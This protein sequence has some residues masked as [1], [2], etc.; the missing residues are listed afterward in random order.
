MTEGAGITSVSTTGGG[1]SALFATDK[2]SAA[3]GSFFVASAALCAVALAPAAGALSALD[4]DISTIARIPSEPISPATH[5]AITIFQGR[6]LGGAE[7]TPVHAD[8]V[9]LRE[10]ESVIDWFDSWPGP[11]EESEEL[12]GGALH[13]RAANAIVAVSS[14]MEAIDDRDRGARTGANGS[15]AAL[16]SSAL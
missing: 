3:T 2:P 8:L 6:A 11:V 4:F 7:R 16:S 5:A 9:W 13:D 10:G 15:K 1:A 14:G 12:E